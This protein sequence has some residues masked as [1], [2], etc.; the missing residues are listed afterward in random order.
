MEEHEPDWRPPNEDG[1]GAT[2]AAAERTAA[3]VLWT[4]GGALFAGLTTLGVLLVTHTCTAN[5]D[6]I[7]VNTNHLSSLEA[8][9]GAVSD[10]QI[11]NERRI[12]DLE[13]SERVPDPRFDK[14]D[15]RMDDLS[16]IISTNLSDI[17]HRL[18][19]MDARMQRR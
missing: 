9:L 10:R 12:M 2:L 1:S 17:R 6:Q 8:R 19:S 16:L 3:R 7:S 18:D 15:K 4:L 14:I 11:I 5:S 13:T